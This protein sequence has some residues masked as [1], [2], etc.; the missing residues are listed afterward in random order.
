MMIDE[1][2]GWKKTVLQSVHGT[3]TQETSLCSSLADGLHECFQ[4]SHLGA[5]CQHEGINHQIYCYSIIYVI[6]ICVIKVIHSAVTK[7][8]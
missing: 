1:A 6:N 8:I 5:I 3:R 7:M 2:F 4:A